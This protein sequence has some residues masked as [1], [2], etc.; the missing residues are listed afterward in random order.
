MST[1]WRHGSRLRPLRH[2]GHTL[3]G[4]CLTFWRVL[5]HGVVG[6]RSEPSKRRARARA[7]KREVRAVTG[8]RNPTGDRA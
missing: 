5:R 4:C 2:F 8:A 3:G 6:E 1:D 7:S